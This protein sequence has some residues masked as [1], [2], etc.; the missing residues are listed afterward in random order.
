M[1]FEA[2]KRVVRLFSW[3]KAAEQTIQVYQEALS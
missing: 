2:R 1:A 3:D